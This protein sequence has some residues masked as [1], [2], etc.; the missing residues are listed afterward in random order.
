MKAHFSARVFVGLLAA[1]I[2]GTAGFAQL[3]KQTKTIK[4]EVV[5]LWC[6]MDHGA[7]GEKHKACAVACAK[8][9]N[10]I[11]IVDAEGNVYVA[12]GSE[13]HQPDRD[14]LIEKMAQHVTVTGTVISRGG[15]KMLYV[16]SIS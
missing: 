5:D 16:K 7:H 13:L 3:N 11:G 15:L 2:I 14:R 10:P 9:G 6:Y 4:G 8:L 12:V 1:L